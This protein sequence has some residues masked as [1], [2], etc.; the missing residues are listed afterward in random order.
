MWSLHG[1]MH[2]ELSILW[3]YKTKRA[4]PFLYQP[5]PR[6]IY[7]VFCKQSLHIRTCSR[8]KQN[9]C[10]G[11]VTVGACNGLYLVYRTRMSQIGKRSDHS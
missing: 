8:L 10:D 3:Q 11:V 2:V 7:G 4:I 5:V 9:R 6:D 1:V